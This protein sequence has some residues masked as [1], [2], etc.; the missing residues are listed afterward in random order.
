[1]KREFLV[2]RQGKTFVLYA[3]LLEE[4]FNQGLTS[5]STDLIQAPASDNGFVAICRS[6]VV[7]SKGS[8]TGIGDASPDNVTRMLAPHYIRMAETRA[9]A[10]A[11][12]D[13]VNIGV[14]ALE[15]LGEV[16]HEPDANQG[17]DRS[18][19][20]S[21]TAAVE[22]ER[23]RPSGPWAPATPAQIKAIYVIGRNE[24]HLS[25]EEVDDRSRRQ[26][27]RPATELSKWEAME[28][29]DQL[30]AP[31]PAAEPP[32]KPTTTPLAARIA[33]TP[34]PTIDDLGKPKPGD[35]W[36]DEKPAPAT[37]A[38]GQRIVPKDDVLWTDPTNGILARSDKA[39]ALGVD[40]KALL[41]GLGITK[42]AG[43]LTVRQCDDLRAELQRQI[44][45]REHLIPA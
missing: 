39:I 44:E 14:T 36:D 43:G 29:I 7:T 2:E 30:K 12:R 18:F 19:R 32:P 5:I 6:T 26:Y 21:I 20:E 13:A 27:G 24:K 45:Q 31:D 38:P 41:A 8:F 42:W 10:R 17:G 11:L 22:H 9:K 23:Q 40:M 15:E 33:N 35:P 3:G 28:F 37:V 16:E 4:A 34:S 25:E 1:M